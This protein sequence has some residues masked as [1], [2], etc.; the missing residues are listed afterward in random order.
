LTQSEIRDIILGADEFAP[1]QLH[2]A[3]DCRDWKTGR[4]SKS[5]E[6]C[7]FQGPP[8][9]RIYFFTRQLQLCEL[10][11]NWYFYLNSRKFF[12][13]NLDQLFC[14]FQFCKFSLFHLKLSNSHLIFCL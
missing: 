2:A 6:I 9:K 14:L 10:M 3:S 12:V 7:L 8:A 11:H 1:P 13:L 4:W 5:G